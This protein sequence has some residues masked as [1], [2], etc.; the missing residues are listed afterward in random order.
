MG[1][2]KK[3]AFLLILCAVALSAL[4]PV[5]VCADHYIYYEETLYDEERFIHTYTEDTLTED[6]QFTSVFCEG[7]PAL[8]QADEAVDNA[9]AVLDESDSDSVND[10][11]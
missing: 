9:L 11:M 2:Y 6:E 7:S 8:Q 1:F 10:V 3:G 4:L 5:T